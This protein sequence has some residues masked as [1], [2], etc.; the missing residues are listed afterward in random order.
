MNRQSTLA[1][2]AVWAPVGAIVAYGV[3]AAVDFRSPSIL[4]IAVLI[5]AAYSVVFSYFKLTQKLAEQ[6]TLWQGLLVV[7]FNV[8]IAWLVVASRP[9]SW[10]S[11]GLAS[12]LLSFAAFAI[13]AI[14]RRERETP[15]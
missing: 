3:G 9:M 8:L 15:G 4:L 12:A 7:S 1:K 5:G 13:L 14:A 6:R 2:I 10:R 11:L